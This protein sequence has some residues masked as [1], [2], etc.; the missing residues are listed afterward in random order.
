MKLG[1]IRKMD[2]A[3]GA[4][5]LQKLI[6]NKKIYLKLYKQQNF[7]EPHVIHVDAYVD[8]VSVAEYLANRGVV[9]LHDRR[10]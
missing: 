3:H 9:Q 1:A 4:A 5:E 2:S 6:G 10:F 7:N 8:N